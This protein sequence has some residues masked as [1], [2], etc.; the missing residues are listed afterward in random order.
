MQSD[1]ILVLVYVLLVLVYVL[2]TIPAAWRITSLIRSEEGP[3]LIFERFRDYIGV[4][5]DSIEPNFQTKL[6]S[7]INCFSV[8][9]GTLTALTLFAPTI[10]LFIAV[11]LTYSA[12]IIFL[13][14]ILSDR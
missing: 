3:F 13:E 11:P 7:C 10:S 14:K 9:S 8:W 5:I 4:D 12:G 2:L 6:F 1:Y